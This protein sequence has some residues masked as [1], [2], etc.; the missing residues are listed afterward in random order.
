WRRRREHRV[1]CSG[2]RRHRHDIA[3]LRLCRAGSGSPGLFREPPGKRLVATFTTRHRIL[4]LAAR[5]TLRATDSDMKMRVMAPERTYLSQPATIALRRV[6]EFLL[7]TRMNEDSLDLR[8]ARSAPQHR[9]VRERPATVVDVE[10]VLAQHGGRTILFALLHRHPL[11]RHWREP[12]V[13][14]KTD[15]VRRMARQH[16]AAARLRDV[17]DQKPRPSVLGRITR[18]LL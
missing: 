7:D 11:G 17:A 2:Q 18:E 15:L 13:R 8:V 6:A 14:I 1:A 4:R 9:L 12:D 10:R 5:R 3:G 16:R